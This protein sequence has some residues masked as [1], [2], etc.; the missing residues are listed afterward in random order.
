MLDNLQGTLWCHATHVSDGTRI[1]CWICY[2]RS[3]AMK[4][5]LTVMHPTAY[6][7]SDKSGRKGYTSQ[8]T[9]SARRLSSYMVE[10]QATVVG[11]GQPK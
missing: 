7:R 6:V 5:F 8:A 11:W 2:S 9:T 1:A 3:V 4:G 10:R